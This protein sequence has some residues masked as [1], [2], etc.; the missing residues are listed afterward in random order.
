MPN[1]YTWRDN[2]TVTQIIHDHRDLLTHV[3]I[4]EP[5]PGYTLA[6][7]Q[8]IQRRIRG[9]LPADVRELYAAARP[10]QV[11]EDHWPSMGL[12]KPDSY[13]D[14]RWYDLLKERPHPIDLIT[15]GELTFDE[16]QDAQG[17]MLGG[18]PFFDRL[19]WIE[20]HNRHPDGCILLTNHEGD[21]A[22]PVVARSLAEYLSRLCFFN[23]RELVSEPGARDD[24][25]LDHAVVFAR[26]FA[27][28]NPEESDWSEW[29]ARALMAKEHPAGNPLGY[30]HWDPTRK[31]LIP[32]AKA[33]DVQDI[34]LR[35]PTDAEVESIAKAGHCRRLMLLNTPT[36][37][38]SPLARLETLEELYLYDI[39]TIDASPL[40]TAPN[41]RDVCFLRCEVTGL[42]ALA[43]T[44]RL[45]RLRL[46]ESRY[47][48]E[49]LDR[50]RSSH[51]G[52]GIER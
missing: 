8:A 6:E 20:G 37:N 21:P 13:D 44:P 52:L 40:A 49:D 15:G 46:P 11:G 42:G 10:R 26:E 39:T 32:I 18:T 16:L 33:G 5:G 2:R 31:E 19:F 30:H 35:H 1:P 9:P 14:V 22:M 27:E 45:R 7:F 50:V 29:A 12:F 48:E 25:P 51:T 24:L 47:T 43:A 34:T 17:L 23:G 38:L 3:G 41:L 36:L 4:I 28:L